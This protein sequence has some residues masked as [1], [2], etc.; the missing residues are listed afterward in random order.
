[1]ALVAA[2]RPQQWPK[3]LLVAVGAGAVGGPRA[4]LT[5]PTLLLTVAFVAASAAVYLHNDLVD[6]ELDRLDPQKAER[7]VASGVVHIRTATVSAGVLGGGAILL[8]A[9]GGSWWPIVTYLALNVLY[10][11]GAKHVPWVETL[12]VT[13]G[14]PLR[15]LTGAATLVPAALVVTPVAFA[16]VV[17]KRHGELLEGHRARPAAERYRIRTLVVLRRVAFA[18]A[19]TV[20]G[21]S[22]FSRTTS[23][24]AWAVAATFGLVVA[25]LRFETTATRTGAARPDQTARRDPILLAGA[26]L[27]AIGTVLA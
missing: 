2:T 14:F 27:W 18:V 8:A 17:A 16:I 4:L 21:A 7:P 23:A 24:V 15:V 11:R 3:N 12:P 6:R 25:L 20:N 26:A 10:T 5:V 22:V 9:L 1:M 13:L 19:V